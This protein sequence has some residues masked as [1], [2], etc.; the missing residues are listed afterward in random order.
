MAGLIAAAPLIGA[1]SS[2][3]G[4]VGGLMGSKKPKEPPPLTAPTP[5][6]QPATDANARAAQSALFAKQQAS[7]RASTLIQPSSL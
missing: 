7:G 3:A 1:V 5:L 2:L 6:P 4:A